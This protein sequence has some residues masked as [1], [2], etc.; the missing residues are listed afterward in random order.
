MRSTDERVQ[1]GLDGIRKKY[2][3]PIENQE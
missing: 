2:G 3:L 1:M